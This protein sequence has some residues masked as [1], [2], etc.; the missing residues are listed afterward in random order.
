MHRNPPVKICIYRK[1]IMRNLIILAVL[2][3][4][5]ISCEKD[6]FSE[7]NPDVGQFVNL[8]KTVK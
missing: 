6:N 4:F 7:E 2:T 8:L 5:F 3:F 1:K